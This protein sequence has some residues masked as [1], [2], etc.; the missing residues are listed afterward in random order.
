MPRAA[1]ADS[2]AVEALKLCRERAFDIVISDFK[3]PEMNGAELLRAVQS[4]NR[5][6]SAFS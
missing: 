5:H 1:L 6:R 2:A 3:M 4:L